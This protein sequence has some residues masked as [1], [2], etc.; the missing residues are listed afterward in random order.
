MR[1]RPRCDVVQPHLI[2]P[3]VNSKGPEQRLLSL[4]KTES[5][6]QSPPSF[7]KGGLSGDS[8]SPGQSTGLG[9]P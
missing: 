6:R 2:Q 4:Y 8:S 5:P 9:S 1:H 7:Q 3:P